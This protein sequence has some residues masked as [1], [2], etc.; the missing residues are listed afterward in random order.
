M[1]READRSI[2]LLGITCTD[3]SVRQL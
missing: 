1:F 2:P 3:R